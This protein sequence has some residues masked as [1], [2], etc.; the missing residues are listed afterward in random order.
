MLA[1]GSVG[2]EAASDGRTGWVKEGEVEIPR[3]LARP[4]NVFD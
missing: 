3:L 4:N 2:V 1:G